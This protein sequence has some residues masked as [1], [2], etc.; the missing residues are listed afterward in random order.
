MFRCW[1]QSHVTPTS[2]PRAN[3]PIFSYSQIHTMSQLLMKGLGAH[4]KGDFYF[5]W[6]LFSLKFLMKHIWKCC[7][8]KSQWGNVSG[9]AL[10]CN[11]LMHE[12]RSNIPMQKYEIYVFRKSS[13]LNELVE[14]LR[15]Q[16][17]LNVFDSRVVLCIVYI[18]NLCLLNKYTYMFILDYLI[19]YK[20]IL[21]I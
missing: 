17:L 4:M 16:R 21:M 6:K 14:E 10:Q 20:K 8:P 2:R 12:L 19:K 1:E 9:K 3:K 13:R 15:R 7:K 18:L 11:V 5:L